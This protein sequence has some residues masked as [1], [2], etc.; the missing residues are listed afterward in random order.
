MIAVAPA[1]SILSGEYSVLYGA[2]ALALAVQCYARAEI[3]PR[4][5]AKIALILEDFNHHSVHTPVSLK[6]L[7]QQCDE[8]YQRYLAGTIDITELTGDLATLPL[9]A[10]AL[11]QE[12]IGKDL[13]GGCRIVLSSGIP[14]GAGMG[15]SAAITAAV[16]A[17]LAETFSVTLDRELLVDITQQVERLQHGHSSGLDPAVCGFG[18]CLR[19][20]QGVIEPVNLSLDSHWYLVETGSPDASTGECVQQVRSRHADSPI[21]TD[22]SQVTERLQQALVQNDDELLLRSLRRNHRLLTQLGVVP[23]PVQQFVSDLESQGGAAKISGA[24]SIRGDRA[25][26]LLIRAANFPGAL[27]QRYGYRIYPLK[28]DQDGTRVLD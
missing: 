28:E 26:L 5:G 12:R 15:S 16:V 21:W 14:I 19:F 10:L 27:C 24:G 1:K 3:Q 2:P 17:A 6:R 9:Y 23:E 11:L 4:K 8:R 25:G 13:P 7:K 20:Q 22:F 18:G